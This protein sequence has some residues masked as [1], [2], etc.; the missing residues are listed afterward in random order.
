MILY[1]QK[2]YSEAYDIYGELSQTPLRSAEL[3]YEASRCK[4]RLNDT[5]AQLA[6]LDSAVCMFSRPL[7]QEAAPY[8]LARAQAR[9][10]AA[11]YRDAVNDLNDYEQLMRSRLTPNFYYIRFQAE[12]GGRL[13]QQALND[14]RKAI[15]LS[16]TYDLY[17]AEKASLEVRVGL[18]DDAIDTATECVRIAPEYSDGYLFLGLAQCL[19]GKKEE[20]VENLRK[21]KSLGDPQADGLIEKYAR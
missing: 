18:Y 7:L 17:Y 12:V 16:P 15:E 4:E 5:V 10:D 9:L 20:G 8:L 14:I 11:R 13:F 2:N 1:A 19:K 3:F 21:A 6:L